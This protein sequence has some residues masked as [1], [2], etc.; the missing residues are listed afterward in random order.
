MMTPRGGWKVNDDPAERNR[1][2][3]PTR[4]Q[5]AQRSDT[6]PDF[7]IYSDE[8]VGARARGR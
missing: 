3:V 1:R 7:E 8:L 2:S 5:Y 4:N 6:W